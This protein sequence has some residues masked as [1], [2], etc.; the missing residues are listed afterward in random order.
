M[1]TKRYGNQILIRLEKGEEVTASIERVC[2]EYDVKAGSISGLGAASYAKICLYDVEKKEFSNNEI[3]MPLEIASITGNVSEMNGK[4]YLHNHIV[5]ADGTGKCYG[6]HLKEAVISATAEI[7]ITVI[8][9]KIGRRADI[10]TGL[11]L[12]KLD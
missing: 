4:V 10:E 6:G 9:G 3:N 8:D 5:L 12:L 7:L 2:T 11:N 1:E